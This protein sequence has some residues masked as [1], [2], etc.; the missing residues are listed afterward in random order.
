MVKNA[1]VAVLLVAWSLG[2]SSDLV[3]KVL[4]WSHPDLILLAYPRTSWMMSGDGNAYLRFFGHLSFKASLQDALLS[5]RSR[6]KYWG[7]LCACFL[8]IDLLLEC[9][10]IW[11]T[12]GLLGI[13]D[14]TLKLSC[15]WIGHLPGDLSL[16]LPILMT[17]EQDFP[18]K[19]I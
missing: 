19:T 4:L 10:T 7:T 2:T 15:P 5:E 3:T 18:H 6:L 8:L 14:S 11:I 13:T 12:C 9:P 16:L 1:L 17:F